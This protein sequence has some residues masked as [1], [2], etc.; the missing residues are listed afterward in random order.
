MR[1]AV[2]LLVLAAVLFYSVSYCKNTVFK[3]PV[4]VAEDFRMNVEDGMTWEQVV[5]LHKPHWYYN[6]Y[7][8]SQGF[9][10]QTDPARYNHGAID[11]AVSNNKWPVGFGFEYSFTK[12][13]AWE[14]HFDGQG[15]LVYIGDLLT[16]RRMLGKE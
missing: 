5:E 3:D 2:I 7:T 9:T 11:D 16:F 12:H 15:Q 13:H 10:H 6:Y 1:S 4:L 14:L 8:D